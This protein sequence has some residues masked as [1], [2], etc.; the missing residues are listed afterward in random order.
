M[1]A[2]AHH[3]PIW[4]RFMRG[5]CCDFSIVRNGATRRP[6]PR[7]WEEKVCEGRAC[8]PRLWEA[9]LLACAASVQACSDLCDTSLFPGG[10]VLSSQARQGPGSPQG[11]SA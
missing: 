3:R 1:G 5:M 7:G 10:H 2:L 4:K 6:Q 9:S 8:R 11:F